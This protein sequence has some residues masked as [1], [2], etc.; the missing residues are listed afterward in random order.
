MLCSS[1]L[2]R[3]AS[4]LFPALR[5]LE[6]VGWVRTEWSSTENDRRA[7]YY[8]LTRSGRARL[9]AE[10]REWDRQITA[11]ARILAAT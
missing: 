11:I 6:R 9:A 10:R 2:G 7:K 5:R 1:P 8:I 3:Q 4:T